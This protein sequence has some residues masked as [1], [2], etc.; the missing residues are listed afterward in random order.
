MGHIYASAIGTTVLQLKE[1][2]PRPPEYDGKLCLFDLAPG[3]DEAAIKE[4]LAPYGNIV[5]CTLGRNPPAAVRFTTHAAAQAA[6]RAAAQLAH[7]AGGVDTLFNERSYDGRHGEAGLDNDEGRGWC[8]FESAVSGELILRLS[9]FPRIKA[10]L[11]KLPPKMLKL[12]SGWPLEAVDLSAGQL[13]TRVAEVVDSIER[14]IFTGKGDKPMVIGLY[15]KYVERIAGALQRLLPKVLASNSATAMQVALPPMPADAGFA[16]MKA[17]HLDLLR[18]QHAHILDALSGR[19]LSTLTECVPIGV[20]GHDADGNPLIVRDA[21]SLC[22]WLHGLRASAC[23]CALLTAGPAAGKTWLMSQL[24]MHSLDGNLVP[25]LVDGQRLQK[26][27]A[28]H[29]PVFAAA[30]DWIDA[31][32]RLTC[33]P[34]HYRLLRGAMDARRALLLLDGLDEAG[35]ERPRIERH[36][37]EVLAPQGLALLCTSRPAG[38]DEAL[39]QG[40]HRLKLAPLSDTQQAAFLATRLTPTRADALLPY[41]RDKVPV[42]AETRRRV[43]SNPLMLSMIASIAEL[44]AGIAMPTR[45]AELYEV[46][47]RAML[48]RGGAL[49]DEDAALLQ[50][51]FFEAHAVQERVITE[52]HL[53]A[54]ATHLGRSAEELRARVMDDRLP[55]LRVLQESPLQMQAFHLCFQEF[56][57]MRALSEGGARALPDFRVGDPWWTNAV[58]MGVQTGDA[59]GERFVEAAGL[60]GEA[61]EG[62]RARLVTALAHAGLPGAWLPIVAEAAGAPA[63]YAKLKRFAGRNRDVLQ[64][65]GGKAVAQLVLQQP[66]TSVVLDLLK[67][68][69]LQRLIVW[70]NKPQIDDP[71]V[72]TFAHEGAVK[73]VAVLRTRIVGGAGKSVY[74]YDA[75]TEELIKQLESTCDVQA[76]QEL[77]VAIFED[78][79]GGLITAGCNQTIKVWDAGELCALQSS[80]LGQS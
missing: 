5:G 76:P 80:L 2:P 57:A 25:I 35:R 65:E 12:R 52:V 39:F 1:L 9:A 21:P 30:P 54:A 63:E 36:V 14:A 7:V 44:R 8:V 37:V 31:F 45:T 47:A 41:L 64:R 75:N 77:K 22:T 46:A 68:T 78:E 43:T 73:S 66:Q 51:T 59:F 72:A 71:C 32:L 48:A 69:P 27:L 10:E 6:K 15:T 16:S 67:S 33:A 34:A 79:Q 56:Y 23:S 55:L 42:D 13:E 11:D 50:A 53:T 4:A 29:A 70:R 18:A 17:W 58:L 40:F 49:P 3:V 62:W 24:I 19:R 26:A 74:V 61:G 38:L 20:E 28:E 60:G